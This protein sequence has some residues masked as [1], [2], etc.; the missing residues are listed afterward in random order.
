M[1]YSVASLLLAGV[2]FN[3]A[4]QAGE[5]V[6]TVNDVAVHKG[7]LKMALFDSAAAW[8]GKAKAIAQQAQAATAGSV[9]FRFADLPGGTYAISVMHDENDNG[10]MDSNFLGMPT[11][12]YAFSNDPKVMRKATFEEAAFEVG[13]DGAR[14]D[15]HLR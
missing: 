12:G 13:A 8:D 2:L 9:E 4:A 11:E 14:I 7:Q 5:L 3:A 6:V 1:K 15:M 10:R